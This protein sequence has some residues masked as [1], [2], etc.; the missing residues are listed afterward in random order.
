MVIVKKTMKYTIFI[1]IMALVMAFALGLQFSFIS[2]QTINGQTL[3]TFNLSGY[4]EN[5]SNNWNGFPIGFDK[6]LPPR[7][8]ADTGDWWADAGNN[9]ALVFD[10]IYF[11]LNLILY[12]IRIFAWVLILVL[13]LLGFTM[14]MQATTITG[15]NDLLPWLVNNLMI[16]YI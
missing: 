6:I 14:N 7:T 15:I 12:I 13:S 5:L 16:P 8:W 4:L 2:Q 10:W 9:I 3:T 1:G 11:P